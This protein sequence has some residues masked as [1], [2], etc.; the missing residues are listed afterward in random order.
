MMRG[1]R[2]GV[3]HDSNHC[4]FFTT[5][6]CSLSVSIFFS[7]A[8]CL[9]PML[10]LSVPFIIHCDASVFFI[11]QISS[12]TDSFSGYVVLVLYLGVEGF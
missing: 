10:S 5:P 6:P 12:S 8:H 4:S 3:A 9:S 1:E 2:E 11:Q 7:F